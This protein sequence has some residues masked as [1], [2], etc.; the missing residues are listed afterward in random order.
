[1][2]RHKAGSLGES[3]DCRRLP[4]SQPCQTHRP[5]QGARRPA[6][7]Q[8]G[9]QGIR[10]ACG[11]AA[12]MGQCP[13]ARQSSAGRSPGRTA[14]GRMPWPAGKAGGPGEKSNNPAGSAIRAPAACA[15]SMCTQVSAASLHMLST[16]SLLPGCSK[17]HKSSGSKGW[18]GKG[19]QGALASTP[20]TMPTSNLHAQQHSIAG[21]PTAPPLINMEHMP[22]G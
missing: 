17:R 19:E 4:P 8:A 10:G 3:Y 15:R 1:M 9:G 6:G 7:M 11:G 20:P 12:H 21:Q 22:A 14:P 5:Q 16:R 2:G 18:T 13:F